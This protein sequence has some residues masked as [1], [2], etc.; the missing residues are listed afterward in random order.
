MTGKQLEFDQRVS[1]LNKKHDK[2]NR[3]YRATVR[4]DGLVVMKPLRVRSAIPLK[5]LV[6]IVCGFFAFKAFLLSVLGSS[7]YELRV[8]SLNEGTPVEQAGAW[9]MQTDPLSELLAQQM[10]KVF[11]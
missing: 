1:R 5:V 11:Y 9:V 2:L 7:G 3:G 10:N 4:S 6:M 8:N